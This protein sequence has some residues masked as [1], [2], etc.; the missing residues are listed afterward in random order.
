MIISRILFM[1]IQLLYSQPFSKS[2]ECTKQGD[3]DTMNPCKATA[4]WNLLSLFRLE[5]LMFLR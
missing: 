2:D 3:A 5:Y 1:I 4:S